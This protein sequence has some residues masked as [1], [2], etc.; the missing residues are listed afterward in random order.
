MINDVIYLDY[1]RRFSEEVH[2]WGMYK[3]Q[4]LIGR[5]QTL[6]VHIY[7]QL[8]FCLVYHHTLSPQVYELVNDAY[9]LCIM[10]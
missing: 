10:L 7:R 8:W 1:F 9:D 6:F 3:D 2:I 5:Y 4:I